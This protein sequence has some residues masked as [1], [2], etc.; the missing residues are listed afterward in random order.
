M[1]DSI[2][3]QI[4]IP[5]QQM[6]KIVFL[7]LSLLLLVSCS[8][9]E[10]PIEL[11]DANYDE[12]NVPVY[13]F[14]GKPYEGVATESFGENVSIKNHIENGLI[15]LTEGFY[16]NGEKERLIHYQN[17]KPHGAY[18]MWYPDGTVYLKQEY[19]D[20]KLTGKSVLYNPLG[21]IERETNYEVTNSVEQE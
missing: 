3:Y 9:P 4:Y 20:G 12:G 16:Q 5:S 14:N 11:L 13:F 6:K 17:G 8:S 15:T 1:H 18:T 19:K 7:S 2:K 10:M 21:G